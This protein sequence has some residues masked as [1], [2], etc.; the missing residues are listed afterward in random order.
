MRLSQWD[1]KSR[2]KVQDSR[3]S[4]SCCPFI[5]HQH[6][7]SP[8]RYLRPCTLGGVQ[9]GSHLGQ[10][11]LGV[12]VSGVEREGLPQVRQRVLGQSARL[13]PVQ[14]QQG[15]GRVGQRR[16]GMLQHDGGLWEEMQI[17]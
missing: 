15:V 11:A 7:S 13:R 2:V 3:S 6:H 1:R 10:P 4:T 8:S 12:D 16:A 14:G 5:S 17:A 9:D